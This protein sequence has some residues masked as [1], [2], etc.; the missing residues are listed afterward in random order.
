MFYQHSYLLREGGLG[1]LSVHPAVYIIKSENVG[2]NLRVKELSVC[3]TLL[4][5]DGTCKY[6]KSSVKVL[7]ERQD[8]L[9]LSP[10][11]ENCLTPAHGKIYS[12]VCTI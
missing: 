10:S 12:S 1:R 5:W 8:V 2:A 7:Q 11:V 3:L 9:F 4:Q 6:C